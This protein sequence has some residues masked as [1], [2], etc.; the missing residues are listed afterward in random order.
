[1][2]ILKPNLIIILAV[3]AILV[4]GIVFF[5]QEKNRKIDERPA[6]TQN[7]KN[8]N[9]YRNPD[10]GFSFQ[11]PEGM[12]LQEFDDE[13][14][15]VILF[16]SSDSSHRSYQIFISPF[17]EVNSITPARIKKDL[18]GAVV[19]NPTSIKV[20]GRD[21]LSFIGQG[22][23][24][25]TAEVWFIYPPEPHPNGN[26]FYQLTAKLEDAKLVEEVLKTWKFQ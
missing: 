18:P 12:N 14:G 19:E 9:E 22:D 21:A 3:A 15:H 25:K 7:A 26:Y 4:G 2:N 1:M 17:D 16:D 13:N 23:N 24:F 6:L 11:Y 20:G 8:F 5:A 10:F